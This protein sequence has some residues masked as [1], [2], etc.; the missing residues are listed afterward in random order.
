M[1]SCFAVVY[2][3]DDTIS[4][5]KEGENPMAPESFAQRE[6]LAQAHQLGE[7]QKDYSLQFHKIVEFL[8]LPLILA[9]V[10]IIV[11][12]VSLSARSSLVVLECYSL[13]VRNCLSLSTSGIFISTCIATGCFISIGT[14]AGSLAGSKSKG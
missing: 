14:Q 5:S 6:E 13:G 1:L 12:R 9:Y 10:L 2:I 3:A 7:L 8:G 11:H 4:N